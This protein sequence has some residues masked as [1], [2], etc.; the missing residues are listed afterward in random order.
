MRMICYMCYCHGPGKS[1]ININYFG[2][3]ELWVCRFEKQG[4]YGF[5]TILQR[6]CTRQC[7]RNSG[8]CQARKGIAISFGQLVPTTPELTR[9]QIA[10]RIAEN[11][12]ETRGQNVPFGAAGCQHESNIATSIKPAWE[13]GTPLKSTI[14]ADRNRTCGLRFRKPPLGTG[15]HFKTRHLRETG[16]TVWRPAWCFTGNGPTP[17]PPLAPCDLH[18]RLRSRRSEARRLLISVNI[19]PP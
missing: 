18:R 14:A 15:K 11:A 3:I 1:A 4:V 6:Q 17:P 8:R 7:C 13:A 2:A 10:E 12:L 16:Q 19:S 9:A 5:P